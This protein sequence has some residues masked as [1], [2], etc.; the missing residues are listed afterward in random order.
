M[1]Y[2]G[3]RACTGTSPCITDTQRRNMDTKNYR[4]LI[5]YGILIFLVLILLV[6][7]ISI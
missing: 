6:C 7:N 5:A 1:T 3:T 2:I 4:F